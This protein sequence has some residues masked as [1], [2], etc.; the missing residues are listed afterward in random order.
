MKIPTQYQGSGTLDE[1]DSVLQA[2][3]KGYVFTIEN[4]DDGTFDMC[5]GCDNYYSATLTKEQLIMLGQEIIERA[6]S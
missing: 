5:E 4:N 6:N 1:Y 3:E 2:M